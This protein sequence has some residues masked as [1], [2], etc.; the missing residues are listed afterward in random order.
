MDIS[1]TKSNNLK[2]IFNIFP[3]NI[4][5]YFFLGIFSILIFIA[6]FIQYFVYGF[7]FPLILI[8]KFRKPAL[9]DTEM[10]SKEQKM[11]EK[12]EAK[13]RKQLLAQ[14]VE[15]K[16]LR[17]NMAS[18]T[19]KDEYIDDS[20]K[21]EKPSLKTKLDNILN[22]I[23]SA[24]S[25]FSKKIKEAK[26]NSNKQDIDRQALLIDMSA[27]N[28][29]KSTVKLMYQYIAKAPDGKTIKGYFEGYSKTEVLSYLISEGYEVYNIKTNKYIQ[30]FHSSSSYSKAKMANKDLIFFLTQLST[31]IKSGIPLVDS[32]KILSKQYKKVKYKELFK[33][34]IYELSTGESLSSAMSKQ[35]NAFPKILINMIKASEMTGE[36]PETLDD[37][38]EYF[39]NIEKTRKQMITAMMY[40]TIIFV[41]A[42]GVVTF[43]LLWVIPR[44]V[45]I[46]A[47][48]DAKIPA[49]TQMILN[50]SE[51]L[52]NYIYYVFG[53]IIAFLLI[54]IYL[55][56]NVKS[57]R[58][59]MQWLAMHIPV[60]SNVIIYN[61]VTI[62]TKT[63]ASLL[64]HNVFI[65]DSMEILNQVTD[66]EIYRALIKDTI[67]NLAKGEKISKSFE[68]N[69][70][71][72][73]PAY[74]MLVTGE[75]TGQLPE[76]M[77]KVSDYYQ[78][79]H[80]NSVSR[81]KTLVEPV[82]IVF[83]TVVVGAIILAIVIP[84]FGVYGA[85]QDLE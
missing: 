5:K 81:I 76:M 29:E 22:N 27:L 34:L 65:T 83:L 1:S 49:F 80:T 15:E 46:Y 14:E 75:K 25:L 44:F 37:M 19:D 12:E 21:L 59:G 84:M 73:I 51:F 9:P 78:E 33:A 26:G 17:E 62:F 82:L 41:V 58:Y 10:S 69:W 77:K 7:G 52:K 45:D 50:L 39:T 35:G 40:P 68:N 42:I 18:I 36:L 85:I 55:Y 20:V 13:F 23:F 24:P 66:N 54:L 3:L 28:E 38:S 8:N 74:E 72:P 79:L 53:G 60:M 70:A 6:K 16:K 67:V 61:E 57:V 43:I 71:F 64:S 31:Y 30:L 56:K 63:F 11:L 4:F 47:S 48:M 32:L 2:N